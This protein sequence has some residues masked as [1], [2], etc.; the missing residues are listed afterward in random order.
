MA[1]VDSHHTE[2]INVRML[3]NIDISSSSKHPVHDA[4]MHGLTSHL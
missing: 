1:A 4:Q 3:G 2:T